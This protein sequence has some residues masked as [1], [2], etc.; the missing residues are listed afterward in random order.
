MLASLIETCKLHS[1][2]PEAYLT[3]VLTRLVNGWPNKRI[4]VKPFRGGH[5]SSFTLLGGFAGVG[6]APLA[7][8]VNPR[9]CWPLRLEWV[10]T[11]T[12]E[13]DYACGRTP[14]FPS[15]DL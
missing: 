8:S 6:R 3:D 5:G 9:H 7:S 11:K 4:A 10:P 13:R 2:N 12:R 1:V 14:D 15:L